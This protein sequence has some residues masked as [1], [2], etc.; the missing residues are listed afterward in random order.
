ME[1]GEGLLRPPAGLPVRPAAR[2]GA[3][4]AGVRQPA[5]VLLRAVPRRAAARPRASRQARS[6]CGD[7]TR[8]SASTRAPTAW[9]WRSTPRT[10]RTASR[11]AGSSPATGPARRCGA[12]SA[13]TSSAGSS[14]TTSSS[15]T[16]SWRPT[17]RP[18]GG[19]GST[20][21][22]TGG[23]RRCSTSSPTT[24]GASTSSSAAAST[25]TSSRSPRTSSPGCARCSAP[26]C[27][28][29]SNGCRSTPSSAAAWSGSGTAGSSSP[30]TRPTRCRRSGRGA[31]T[32]ASRTPTTSAG[33]SNSSS[34]DARQ[35]GC[36]TRYDHERVQAADEN[37]VASTR[38]T[39]FITP[40]S[41]T[42]RLFRDAVLDLSEGLPFARP[43][44]N[45]GRLSVPCVHDGS[46][47]NGPDHPA[48]PRRTRP[49][50]P[51]SDAPLAD[52]WLVDALGGR[53]RL[54]AIDTPAPARLEVDGL[55]VD[56]L[57]LD[58][59]AAPSDALRERYL[60]DATVGRLPGSSRPARRRAL[61]VVRR[62]G[63][64]A[65]AADR[66]GGARH[67]Q[68][69]HRSGSARTRTSTTRTAST[70][71]CCRCTRAG[72][73]TTATRSTPAWC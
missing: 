16:S 10:A 26:T 69:S 17:S 48:L 33:S 60:G 53:F 2:G 21:R 30:A 65:G 66:G 22:S 6:S 56:V 58:A 37:L 32:A 23:S 63:G 24:S 29:T 70:K 42:S 38:S 55:P 7:A 28:S 12:C 4:A 39:D 67:D 13:P 57:H 31:P 68:A 41:Q 8:S 15:P 20:R 19:S 61:D 1:H 64:R 3:Q 50:A 5:A 18:S 46:P 73:R 25:A 45:S 72:P 47:L 27:A 36:S 40:K 34:K 51:A 9:G 35:S 62:G 44:V 14:R 71:S 54:M 52:G 49:G 11:R 43:L 59:A